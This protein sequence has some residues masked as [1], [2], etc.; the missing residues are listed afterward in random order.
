MLAR[1]SCIAAA[2]RANFQR[3]PARPDLCSPE[4]VLIA[5]DWHGA[6]GGTDYNAGLSIMEYPG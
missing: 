6:E 2:L 1:N 4:N 3:I 5:A